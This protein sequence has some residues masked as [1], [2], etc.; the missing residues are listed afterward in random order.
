[1]NVR[2]HYIAVFIATAAS[3]VAEEIRPGVVRTPEERFEDLPGYPFEPNY[4]EAGG[5]RMHYVDE[6]AKDAEPILMLHGEP[7]WSY[8]YRKMV[9]IFVDA[10]YRAV[11]PDN[12]GFGKSD[13]PADR[14][15]YTYQM[16]VD[17]TTELIETLDL[18]N[19]T[20]VCQDWGGL[21]GLRV[22]AENP[23]RFARIVAS[24]TGLPGGPAPTSPPPEGERPPGPSFAEWFQY[25]QTTPE[26][27]VSEIFKKF[28]PHPIPEDVLAAYDAPF[29]SEKYRAG[30]RALP[31]I[32]LQ[33]PEKCRAAWEVLKKWDKPFLTAFSDGDPITWGGYRVFQDHVPGAKGQPH[34]T[35]KN[36]GHFVQ[37]DQGERFAEVIIDFIEA[38]K[39]MPISTAE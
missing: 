27:V 32:I 35:I 1:M 16:L 10:G 6:G 5:Y 37:E 20:L 7:T 25:S 15:D 22:A 17:T 4:V 2:L 9:P 8:L 23:D 3:A 29:P 34:T 18:Q 19:I 11:A 28:N 21:I 24:N 14:E 33:Q 26:L 13:K 30:A 39:L 38:T 36:A 31:T 12:I